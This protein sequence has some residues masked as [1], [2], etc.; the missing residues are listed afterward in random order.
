MT[1]SC[2]PPRVRSLIVSTV[3]RTGGHLGSNL[4]IVELTIALH[5]VFRSPD[6]VILYDT[7]HQTYP[8]KL[9]TGRR[10]SFANLREPGGLSGYP[11][12]LESDHDWIENSHASTALSYA[13]GFAAAFRTKGEDRPGRGRGR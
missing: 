2:S 12:N 11:S 9:L 8:H 4:G 3:E 5:R 1:W 7:G 6:D 13:H 10:Q